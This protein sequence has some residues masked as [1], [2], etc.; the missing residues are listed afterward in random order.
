MPQAYPLY[1]SEGCRVIAGKASRGRRRA[2]RADTPPPPA[3]SPRGGGARVAARPTVAVHRSGAPGAHGAE[4][5]T[6]TMPDK[7]MR[8]WRHD[9]GEP[10]RP[11]MLAIAGDSAAGKT[12]L[13]RGIAE[14]LGAD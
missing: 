1:R 5:R 7:L 10:R 2:S 11:V 12:T 4:A 9:Q 14:V 3:T 13:T 8:L 6:T